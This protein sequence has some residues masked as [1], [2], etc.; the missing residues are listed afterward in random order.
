MK[1]IA[2]TIFIHLFV[3]LPVFSC[4]ICGCGV[5]G[6]YIGILPDFV[7]KIIGVRYRHNA[8]RTHIGAGGVAPYLTTREIYH[9]AEL[10]GGWNINKKVRVMAVVPWSFN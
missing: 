3:T 9:N 8:L 2:I 7:S 10:W 1:K 4:D 6:N 5:G